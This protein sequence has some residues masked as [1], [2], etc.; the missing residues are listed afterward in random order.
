MFSI[1][2]LAHLNQTISVPISS[3]DS[4]N[5]VVT[6]VAIQTAL[7]TKLDSTSLATVATSGSFNDLTNAPVIETTIVNTT[8]AI[9][10]SAVF[11]FKNNE[12]IKHTDLLTAIG[13]KQDSASAFD[14]AFSSLTGKPTIDAAIADG[15]ANAVAGNAVFD[16]LGLKQNA[17]SS[18]SQ[19]G[20]ITN[21]ILEVSHDLHVGGTSTTPSI[22]VGNTTDNGNPRLRLHSTT[23]NQFIDW[24]G[25][26][27]KV[28][29][30]NGTAI[31]T[32][33]TFSTTGLTLPGQL[34][35]SSVLDATGNLR[36]AVNAKQDELTATNRL[37]AF[38]IGFGNVSNTEFGY[39]N[40]AT[41][42]IQ[43][44]L[45]TI[46]SSSSA[47]NTAITALSARV[48][49]LE[50]LVNTGGR[51]AANN[52][53]AFTFASI[54]IDP[55][56]GS[57]GHTSHMDRFYL[58]N[59]ININETFD[60]ETLN[61]RKQL[62]WQ[63]LVSA[64]TSGRGE[65]LVHQNNARD[66]TAK[67]AGLFTVNVN[68]HVRA[69]AMEKRAMYACYLQVLDYTS[70]KE[71]NT[72]HFLGS[73]YYKDNGSDYDDL[74]MGGTATVYLDVNSFIRIQTGMI[75][76]QDVFSA[77]GFTPQTQ[78]LDGDSS[79]VTFNYIGPKLPS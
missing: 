59:N 5:N 27:L 33:A 20:T 42:N 76:I 72:I 46:V 70:G 9:A 74:A 41:Q 17:L 12:A 71:K 2:D 6:S 43:A 34:T 22:W 32:V 8:N 7:A 48:T 62:F 28:R 10:S 49:A 36:T 1:A 35:C 25:G 15:S 63:G 51:L 29:V 19:S 44:Q 54:K 23:A 69:S 14:G 47:T 40:N 55:T 52:P 67:T 3:I 11:A 65:Y 26:D 66:F 53:V 13:Q 68:L 24:Q 21:P 75:Y 78:Y 64:N 4:S 16:A 57:P 37:D 18:L 38:K 30:D 60:P 31:T 77:N 45:N 58:T 73:A 56:G 39:L 50:A 61:T 79:Y